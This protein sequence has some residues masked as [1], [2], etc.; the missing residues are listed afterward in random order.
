MRVWASLG[1]LG[2]RQDIADGVVGVAEAGKLGDAADVNEIR[3]TSLKVVLEI[4][5]ECVGEGDEIGPARRV[6]GKADGVVCRRDEL[7]QTLRR[8]IAK[9]GDT[10]D[11]VC[12]LGAI[13][14]GVESAGEGN[15]GLY[16]T[17]YG[18]RGKP[19]VVAVIGEGERTVI[20]GDGEDVAGAV[21]GCVEALERRRAGAEPEPRTCAEI[22][23]PSGPL[24]HLQVSSRPRPNRGSIPGPSWHA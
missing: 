22:T 10:A 12:Q 9:L 5:G 3:Q 24:S 2:H 20:V 4:G 15:D 18:R 17:G 8:V 19:S 21:I 1:E 16:A 13:A 11:A 7:D 6:V 14:D 23:L